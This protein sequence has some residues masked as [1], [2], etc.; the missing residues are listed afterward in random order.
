M[1]HVDAR[2]PANAVTDFR[3]F[4]VDIDLSVNNAFLQESVGHI[5]QSQPVN[6]IYWNLK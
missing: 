5:P 3:G 6:H 4:R 1:K 2:G